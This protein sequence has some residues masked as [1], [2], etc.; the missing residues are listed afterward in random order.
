MENNNN[1]DP[2][3]SNEESNNI[4]GKQISNTIKITE[5][6]PI[7]TVKMDQVAYVQGE[8]F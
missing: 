7:K 3:N 5:N 6:E 8:V 1:D 2:E 4:L